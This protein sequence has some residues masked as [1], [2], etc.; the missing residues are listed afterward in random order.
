MYLNKYKYE[1]KIR[2]LI[3]SNFYLIYKTFHNINY[4]LEYNKTVD[5]IYIYEWIKE[6]PHLLDNLINKLLFINN[7]QKTVSDTENK[8]EMTNEKMIEIE[9][10]NR[11]SLLF[12]NINKF[13]SNGDGEC[14][15]L[16]TYFTIN[17]KFYNK[18]INNN[19]ILEILD[20][21]LNNSK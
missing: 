13:I 5:E 7:T 20:I 18:I 19:N 9:Y 12:S 21:T 3:N 8:I 11:F 10:F 6:E 2:K 17:N 15:L 4:Y 16:D 14:N 1:V